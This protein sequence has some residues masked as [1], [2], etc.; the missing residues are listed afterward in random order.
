MRSLFDGHT[1]EEC[2]AFYL[3]EFGLTL[4]P[5]SPANYGECRGAPPHADRDYSGGQPASA[6]YPIVWMASPA[7]RVFDDR[8]SPAHEKPA[9]GDR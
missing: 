3:G 4:T 8:N 7:C 6:S 1:C 5:L 9:R 2:T